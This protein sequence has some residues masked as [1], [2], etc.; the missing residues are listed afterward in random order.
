MLITLLILEWLDVVVHIFSWN[1]IFIAFCFVS[2]F[3]YTTVRESG[4][5]M[6]EQMLINMFTEWGNQWVE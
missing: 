2:H 4:G 5:K 3:A 6:L 1:Y